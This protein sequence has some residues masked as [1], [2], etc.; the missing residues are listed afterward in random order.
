M[1]TMFKNQRRINVQRIFMFDSFGNGGPFWVEPLL[2]QTEDGNTS[3]ESINSILCAIS[4][5][6]FKSRNAFANWIKSLSA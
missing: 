4:E 1:A 2:L 5:N 3:H 6:L